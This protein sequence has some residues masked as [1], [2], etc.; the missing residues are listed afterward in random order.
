MDAHDEIIKHKIRRSDYAEY[1]VNREHIS[2]LTV[3]DI[4]TVTISVEQYA[5]ELHNLRPDQLKNI[6]NSDTLD[7]DQQYIIALHRNMNH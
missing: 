2:S 7:K 4:A 6:A 5:S 3:P 1:L